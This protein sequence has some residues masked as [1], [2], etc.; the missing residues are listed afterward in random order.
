M[1]QHHNQ[2]TKFLQIV[3]FYRDK[4]LYHFIFV[5]FLQPTDTHFEIQYYVADG[6]GLTVINGLTKRMILSMF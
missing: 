1:K 6:L 5:C 3:S 2:K 4:I